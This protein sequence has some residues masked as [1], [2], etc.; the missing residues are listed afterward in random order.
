MLQV[1]EVERL[2]EIAEGSALDDLRR[3]RGIGVRGDR[4]DRDGRVEILHSLQ[5][6]HPVDA[7]HGDVE[8][9]EIGTRG[10]DQ[11]ERSP[12]VAGRRDVVGRV[13]DRKSTRLNS[14]HRTISYAVFCL[15]KK[16]N[17]CRS[18]YASASLRVEIWRSKGGG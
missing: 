10:A 16:S 11:L 18:R 9:D 3:E 4:D 14:S 8:E 12:A 13:G 1:S 17:Y 15:K 5:D 7:P 2:R 6:I